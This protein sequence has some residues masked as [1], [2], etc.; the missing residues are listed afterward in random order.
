MS[1]PHS[2][3][4]PSILWLKGRSSMCRMSVQVRVK[5]RSPRGQMLHD[6]TCCTHFC[7]NDMFANRVVRND[8][9]WMK[10]KISDKTEFCLFLSHNQFLA[11]LLGIYCTLLIN[12]L[13]LIAVD[14]DYL[15]LVQLFIDFLVILV[16]FTKLRN[17]GPVGQ[18]EQLRVLDRKHQCTYYLFLLLL[19]QTTLEN[20]QIKIMAKLLSG[21]E[22]ERSVNNRPYCCGVVE[23]L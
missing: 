22:N 1:L 23:N 10:A 19:K 8:K 21:D 6:V 17:Q 5:G 2:S 20:T 7:N 9:S 14:T 18:S 12:L 11:H 15:H 16:V 13:Q 4:C 3:L